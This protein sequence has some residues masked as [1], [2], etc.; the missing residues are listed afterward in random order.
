M[1]NYIFDC[2]NEATMIITGLGLC[3]K[4]ARSLLEAV[5]KDYSQNVLQAK[6]NAAL[7]SGRK[8]V[9]WPRSEDTKLSGIAGNANGLWLRRP[10]GWT[11]TR[12]VRAGKV[13][14]GHTWDHRSSDA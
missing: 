3:E 10:P 7:Q 11:K 5:R 6:I 4:H 8:I 12:H 14:Y 1:S 2:K 9:S 13:E